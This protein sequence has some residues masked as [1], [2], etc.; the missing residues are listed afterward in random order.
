M[1]DKILKSILISTFLLVLGCL[2]EAEPGLEGLAVVHS[3]MEESYLNSGHCLF[4]V[5]HATQSGTRIAFCNALP[6][7]YCRSDVLLL[8]AGELTSLRAGIQSHGLNTAGCSFD[9]LN[10]ITLIDSLQTPTLPEAAKASST[11][12]AMNDISVR[13]VESCAAVGLETTPFVDAAF[14]SLLPPNF[15]LKLHD[16]SI[17]L[18]RYATDSTCRNAISLTTEE[19]SMIDRIRSGASPSSLVCDTGDDDAS[20][21]D[22]PQGVVNALD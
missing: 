7:R 20:L 18:N 1:D 21:N 22:C 10:E 19:R 5:P 11:K 9:A 16:A 8:D 12:L 14:E 2:K 17:Y 4:S 13:V 6:R 15:Y 3:I